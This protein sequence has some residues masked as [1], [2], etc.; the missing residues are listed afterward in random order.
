MASMLYFLAYNPPVQNKLREEMKRLLPNKDTP[1]TKDVL[2]NAPYL[3]ACIKE[4]L[5]LSPIAVATLRTTARDL[6]L[7]GYQI[8]KGVSNFSFASAFVS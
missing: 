6:V 4:T 1:V 7:S 8:P 5:R 2:L 3:K